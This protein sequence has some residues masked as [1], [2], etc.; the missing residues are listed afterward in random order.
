M[1]KRE[2]F[3]ELKREARKRGIV[4]GAKIRDPFGNEGIVPPIKEW[5]ATLKGGLLAGR[6]L[7]YVTLLDSSGNWAEVITTVPSKPKEPKKETAK[8]P[9]SMTTLIEEAK[10]LLQ[11]EGYEV[12]KKRP[13]PRI[14]DIVR[15]K[16]SDGILTKVYNILIT[17]HQ[18]DNAAPDDMYDYGGVEISKGRYRDMDTEPI[19][20]DRDE[21]AENDGKYTVIGHVDLD[22]WIK[23]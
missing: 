2:Q 17:F 8:E 9:K 22:K 16:E 5:V 15:I 11:K 18:T 1:T 7:N 3:R 23:R 13:D 4:P 10:K 19:W 21:W 12:K 6:A 20:I 14:G